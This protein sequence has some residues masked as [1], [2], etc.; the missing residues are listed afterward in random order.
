[1]YFEIVTGRL[2]RRSGRFGAAVSAT[3]GQQPGV[4]GRGHGAVDRFG[5]A[6][7]E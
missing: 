3:A 2:P 4:A 1:M 7:L 5:R 6:R